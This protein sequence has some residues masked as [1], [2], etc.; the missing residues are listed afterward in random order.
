MGRVVGEEQRASILGI[1]GDIVC[2]LDKIQGG[3]KQK[4]IF[5][6]KMPIDFPSLWVR[7]TCIK[8]LFH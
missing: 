8:S 2:Y 6:V 1:T 5:P 7:H 4:K 3:K